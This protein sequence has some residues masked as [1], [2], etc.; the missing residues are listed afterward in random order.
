MKPRT[1]V[2]AFLLV[3]VAAS[4]AFVIFRGAGKQAT[5]EPAGGGAKGDRL[6]AYYFHGNVR[7]QTCR[8]IE[9]YAEEAVKNGY[10]EQLA[11]GKVE[12]HAVNIEQPGNEHFVRDYSL[13]TRSVVLVRMKDGAEAE[14]KRLD[15]VWN[16]VHNKQAFVDYIYENADPM[17]ESV[18]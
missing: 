14:W 18:H 13:V 3:F 2:T 17:I 12:W 11:S 4:V 15:K 7:C 16:L 5:D 8:T 9:A 1:L 10:P 6:V